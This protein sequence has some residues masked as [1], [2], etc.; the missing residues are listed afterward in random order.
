MKATIERMIWEGK[1]GW[2]VF[3][4]QLEG[5][6]RFTAVG[7]LTSDIKPGLSVDFTGEQVLHPIYG[8]QYKISTIVAIQPSTAAGV[9]KW[10]ASGAIGNVGAVIARRICQHF[11]DETPYIIEHTPER[12]S[13]VPGVGKKRTAGL[14]KGLLGNRATRTLIEWL[15][16][17]GVSMGMINKLLRAF[18]T[19]EEALQE[20][21]RNPYRSLAS[22]DVPFSTLDKI[23]L[24]DGMEHDDPRRL[25]AVAGHCISQA[26]REGHCYV[27]QA[28][29]LT[30]MEGFLKFPPD[31]ELTWVDAGYLAVEEW[32]VYLEWVRRQEV[33]VSE[34]LS[35]AIEEND[36]LPEGSGK[37]IEL[38]FRECMVEPSD[39]QTQAV[40]QATQHMASVITGGPGTGKTTIIQA[41]VRLAEKFDLTVRLLAPTGRAQLRLGQVCERDASTIHKALMFTDRTCE[42]WE[43]DVIVIDEMSMVDLELMSRLVSAIK[44]GGRLVMVGDYH[45]LPS[46]GPGNVLKDIIDSGLVPTVHLDVIFRQ[47]EKSAIILNAHRIIHGREIE[48]GGDCRLDYWQPRDGEEAGAYG[49]RM[50]DRIV[51]MVTEILVKDFDPLTEIQVLLPMYR[52]HPGIDAVNAKLQACLNPPGRRPEMNWGTRAYRVGDKAMQLKNNYKLDVFNGEIGIIMGVCNHPKEIRVQYPGGRMATYDVETI[53]ELTLAYA[54]SIHKSQGSEYPCVV[55]GLSNSHFIMLQRNLIY[56]A[57]TRARKQCTI[58]GDKRAVSIAVQ[59]DKPIYRNTRLL[60]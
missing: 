29:L 41:I 31:A 46:V 21:H 26:M 15:G 20:C 5:G 8:K 30:A 50:E 27:T 47:A 33:W 23:A 32:G 10:L 37:A 43:E 42:Q 17:H 4:I 11:G 1:G 7:Y 16:P 49:G 39:M 6:E 14:I 40:T 56:T 3:A 58:I 25:N 13:E 22:T 28:K 54:V 12:V 55:I 2:T 44:P 38:A 52:H 18:R 51:Q 60:T 34:W 53:P 35:D 24:A 19:P 45:Q 59:N 48:D 9:E 36:M 57:L